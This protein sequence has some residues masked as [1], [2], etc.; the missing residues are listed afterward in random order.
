MSVEGFVLRGLNVQLCL[1]VV[2]QESCLVLGEAVS[3]G[4]HCMTAFLLATMHCMALLLRVLDAIKISI[5]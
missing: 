3:M 4:L 2:D 5:G 1:K